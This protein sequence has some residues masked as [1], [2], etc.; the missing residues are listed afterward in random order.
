M[1]VLV[2]SQQ[3]SRRIRSRGATA[4]VVAAAVAAVIAVVGVG[5]LS[6]AALG[7]SHH[8][9]IHATSAHE[10]FHHGCFG[11][12]PIG[13]ACGTL[14]ESQLHQ[15]VG[16]M[17]LAQKVSMVH[18]ASET[19]DP[20]IGCGNTGTPAAF[21]VINPGAT[22]QTLVA[23]C[24]GQAGINNGVKSLGIPPLRQTDGPAGVRL[25][26]AETALP[27][28][29]GLAA[30]FDPSA[31]NAY[32]QVIGSEGR[33]TNQ[34][35]L[36][37]PMINQAAFV[38][39][40]RNF[41]TLSEDPFL[42]G[43]LVVSEVRGVQREGLIATL[44][45]L[46][47]NDFENSRMNTAIKIDARSLHELELQAFEQ[48]V[49]R[50][51]TGAI[52]CSYSRISQSDTGVDT[53]SC[54]NNL[55]L[56]KIARGTWGFTGWILTDFGAVHRLSDILGGVDSAMPNGNAAG[57]RDEPDPGNLSDPPFNSNVFANGAGFP[58]GAPGS[59][60]TLTQAVLHGRPAIPTDGNYPPIPAT[61][62][63]Q[64]DAALD[65]AVFH[66]LT[67][68]NRARLL[69]GTPYG[70][71]SGGCTATAANCTPVVP[72]RPDLAKL[73]P[74]D[75]GTA[76]TLAVKSATL[77]KDN[78]QALPLS[79]SDFAG[80]G[81]V[82][83]GP[84]A[85]AP[86]VGGGGS[87]HVTPFE[88][89]TSPLSA[90]GSAAGSATVKY[91]QGYDLDGQVVPSSAATVP[92]GTSVLPGGLPAA[93]AGFAGQSGW[94]RQQIS[95]TL[96]PSGSETGACTGSCAPDRV[97][98][99]VDYT[100]NTTTLPGATA[101]RFTTH[102]TVP[103]AP[104]G[105]NSW[106]LKVFVKNQ[107]SAQLFVDG[108]ATA[109]R[110]INLGAY[111]LAGGFGGS[112]VPA[113]DG[114]MQ[115]QKSHD[116]L[117]LQQAAFTAT[118]AAGETHDLD[119]R[120]YGNGTDPLSVR[121]VWVPPD[122]QQQSIAAAVAAASNAKKVVVFAFDDGTEGVDRGVNDQNLGLELPGWQDALISAVAAVNSNVVVVLNTGDAVYMPWLSEVKAVLEMW[123]P[124][125]AGGLATSDVLMGNANPGGKLPL[126]FPDGSAPRPR[127]PTD[128]PGCNPAAIVIPNNSTGTGAND[129]NCP[130]YPGVFTSNPQ[131]GAHTYRTVDMS[132]NGIFQG[133]RWYDVHNQTPLFPFGYGR[134][135]TR[136]SYSHLRIE[137][138]HDNVSVA[139]DLANSGS[140]P[141]AEVAQVYVGSP[142]SP[143][144]PMAV[145]ALAGFQRVFLWPGQ[146]R[147]VEIG[148]TPRAFEYWSTV[149]HDWATASGR[150]AIS[151][152]S[153]SRD[154]RLSGAVAVEDRGGRR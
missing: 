85:A 1:P 142:A 124:G 90:L 4:T 80:K 122:W 93:D 27:A 54:G 21:P 145:R 26:H 72:P 99:T 74:K 65:N 71:A 5:A 35:V 106:Q 78:D 89:I 33:A 9:A 120:A 23:G 48:G 152:G 135:Y 114:L 132:A 123:Y 32:G 20:Q 62:A 14:T 36:Y 115:A 75:F 105:S 116:G 2:G 151:I 39:A 16:D 110:A 19:P 58:G 91:V 61:T 42:A 113:W 60:T 30:T 63:A 47:Q 31:A 100:T 118:F 56:N 137:R 76:R 149:T 95:T 84:T 104:A 141:G 138:R 112:A 70:S 87:A 136:L 153:S 144:V 45:H 25:S 108:L 81:V 49:K 55:L 97:D 103:A 127:F 43:Q 7:F 121:F 129:G 125:L 140:R 8:R 64:W 38:T 17:T 24:V 98:P 67:S 53:Y 11:G 34:D 139:F 131:Q 146:R 44:K 12:P 117:Q 77:L 148:L 3:R 46:A 66:I 57:I 92:A 29:V 6:S 83:M 10:E 41:E 94:L 109:Q 52:M 59:G 130:L 133:Y 69:E 101:W 18:G 13:P 51:H 73:A 88:P 134:S 82:V 107:S 126:T 96:P 128:D 154:I 86:Y 68:M 50:G 147:H 150:R 111:G 79:R 119:L 15:L 22:G 40:G 143:P 102:F 28:P 37:G